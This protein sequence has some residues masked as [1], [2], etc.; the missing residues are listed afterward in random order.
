MAALLG[1][2]NLEEYSGYF[3]INLLDES[4]S[5]NDQEPFK[6]KDIGT[7]MMF[8]TR[9]VFEELE[10]TCKKY[11]NNNVGNTG[12]EFGEQITEYFTTVIDEKGILLS[13]DY[14][15]CRMWQAIGG[16][17]WSAPWV[18]ITHSGDYNFAGQ[19]PKMIELSKIR[20]MQAEAARKQALAE[21]QK[22][23]ESE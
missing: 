13:E 1:K 20:E 9:K 11:T 7:G 6:V 5:F 21:K 15:F 17:V 8:I 10:P 4:Q 2:E 3:A 16:D 18:R 22:T 23:D 14:A 19:F 12:I